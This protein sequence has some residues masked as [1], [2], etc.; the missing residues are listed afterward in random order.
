MQQKT[1]LN[2]GASFAIP[3]AQW[4]EPVE[5]IKARLAGNELLFK[6]AAELVATAEAIVQ[7]LQSRESVQPT[8]E[9]LDGNTARI[10]LGD[11]E[12]E[13]EHSVERERLALAPLDAPG[14]PG[15]LKDVGLSDR[16]ARNV[17]APVIAHMIHPY[18]E[19][20]ALRWLETN[21]ATLELLRL[22]TGQAL[23]LDKLY[24]LTDLLVKHHRAIENALFAR[25]RE[26][27]TSGILSRSD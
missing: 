19:R 26:L 20:E 2:F 24:R 5:I 1:L 17:M 12:M 18:S 3:K 11:A 25:Q 10:Q 15:V 13:N 9:A 4:A 14:L 21:S 6:P 23:R 7:K 22:D 16:D 8:D 27:L